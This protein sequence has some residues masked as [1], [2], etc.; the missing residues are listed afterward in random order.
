MSG[1]VPVKAADRR[2]A[3]RVTYPFDGSTS[4]HSGN[5]AVRIG[6]LSITGCFVET[7]ETMA[8]GEKITVRIHIPNWGPL[9]LKAEVVYSTPPFGYG[10]RF[11]DVSPSANLVLQATIETLLKTDHR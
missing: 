7:M 3:P 10:V 9:E 2:V 11:G 1:V 5:R 8:Q 4:N 6:D